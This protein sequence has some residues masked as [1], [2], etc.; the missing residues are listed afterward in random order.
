MRRTPR[1][2]WRRRSGDVKANEVVAI[3]LFDVKLD[4]GVIKPVKEREII[5]AAG[6]TVRRD[7]GKQ[8]THV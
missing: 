3:Y 8:A 1:R 7:L 5:R 2:R 4:G 6:P